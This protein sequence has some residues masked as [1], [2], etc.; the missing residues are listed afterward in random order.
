MRKASVIKYKKAKSKNKP[1]K[2]KKVQD[3]KKDQL[4]TFIIL[5]DMPGHR[6]KSYGSTSLVE[7]N[8][9]KLIDIQIKAISSFFKYYEIVICAGFDAEN[10]SKYVQ[11]KYKHK[12]IRIVENQLF[13]HYNSCES[14]RLCLNNITN[15]RIFIMDG[16]LLFFKDIFKGFQLEHNYLW[17]EN[18]PSE[19]LEVGVNINE[20]KQVE[21][22]SFGAKHIWSEI[23]YLGES[24]TIELLKRL[25]YNIKYKNKIIFEILNDI[26]A[27]KH[28]IGYIVNNSSHIYK[29]NSIKTYKDIRGKT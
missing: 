12:N 22:F 20:N 6:M 19:S 1:K 26:I 28:E 13:N 24:K 3:N 23:I 29:V 5:C 2:N 9:C 21:Y 14:L 17:I 8:N 4:I 11:S 16:N 15:D 25:L 10:L 27:M 18:Q 7:I